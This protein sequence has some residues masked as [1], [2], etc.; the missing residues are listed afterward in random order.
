VVADFSPKNAAK[1][2]ADATILLDGT[3]NFE[4][5]YLINDLAVKSGIPYVYG[6][7]VGT[8]GMAMTVIPGRTPCLRCI[9]EEPPPAGTAQT[10]DT[11]GVLGP[12]IATIAAYQAAEAIKLMLG[13]PDLVATVLM[14]TDLWAG[15]YRRVDISRAK[16]ADCPCCGLKRFEFLEGERAGQVAALCGQNAVQVAAPG[17][18]DVDL[19]TLAA[20]L[21]PHGTFVHMPS[22]LLRGTLNSERGEDGEA[23]GITVFADG[24][25]IVKG[26]SRPELARTLYARYI[27]A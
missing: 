21:S 9:F 26:T 8:R 2:G 5:R 20:R 18:Q 4:T 7:A 19:E 3:D 16:R 15:V 10:C 27:G 24:R 6:G 22:L 12:I 11:A 1:L 25:A 17:Q 13:R 14:E 23:I